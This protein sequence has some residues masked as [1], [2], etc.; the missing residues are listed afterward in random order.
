MDGSEVSKTSSPCGESS[1]FYALDR[2]RGKE[3]QTS[4]RSSLAESHDEKTYLLRLDDD[5]T[6]ELSKSSFLSRLAK[7]RVE[8]TSENLLL[9]LGD[10]LVSLSASDLLNPHEPRAPL[11][12]ELMCDIGHRGL[13]RLACTERDPRSEQR[14]DERVG[15]NEIGVGE[16]VLV[17]A[18]SVGPAREGAS[19]EAVRRV[20]DK[21][22]DLF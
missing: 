11:Q 13:L 18:V 3:P 14:G 20:L 10:P 12:E 21:G 2:N 5:L 7:P 9:L 1:Q 4:K 15:V 8:D 19:K 22:L 6:L 16:S 17:S